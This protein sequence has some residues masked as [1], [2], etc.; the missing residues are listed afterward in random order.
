MSGVRIPILCFP[1]RATLWVGI[2]LSLAAPA[3]FTLDG[4]GRSHTHGGRFGQPS[5]IGWPSTATGGTMSRVIADRSTSAA[6]NSARS[7][8]EGERKP[9]TWRTN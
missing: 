2:G 9:L 5:P 1:V 6:S 4:V 3:A 7:V 8:A